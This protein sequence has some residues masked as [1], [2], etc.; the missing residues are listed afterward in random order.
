MGVDSPAPGERVLV[1]PSVRDA[2]LTHAQ[3]ERPRECCGLLVGTGTV[4]HLAHPARNEL[5]SPVRFRIDPRDHVQAVRA[6]R[7]LGLDVIGA[8]HSHPAAPAVPSSTDLAE[9]L[10]HF[11][12]VIASLAAGEAG[13]PLRAWWLQGRNFVEVP[14]VTPAGEADGTRCEAHPR[15]SS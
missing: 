10:P 14:L 13:R 7:A 15:H 1:P 5:E 4:V 8:Y 3:R 12:Y 9:A 6:A 11:L 2:I